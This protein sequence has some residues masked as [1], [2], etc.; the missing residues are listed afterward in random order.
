MAIGG[1]APGY[2]GNCDG[3]Q[4]EANRVQFCTD[5]ET[6]KC[7]RDLAAGRIDMPTYNTCANRIDSTCQGFNFP[8]GCSP[9]C[10]LTDACI[11]AISDANNIATTNDMIVQC[12]SNTICGAAT[13]EG[14]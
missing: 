3:G 2:V 10:E 6:Y 8:S 9:S 14:I 11:S 13:L 12:Q 4:C 7:A 1:P 5:L